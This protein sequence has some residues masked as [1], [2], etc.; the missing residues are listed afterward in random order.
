MIKLSKLCTVLSE[1]YPPQSAESWD[2]PGLLVGRG[3]SEIHRAI[4]A[5]ELTPNVLEEARK[6]HAELIITHHPF[7]FKPLNALTDSTPEGALLHALIRENIALYAAHTNFDAA[8]HAIAEKLARDLGISSYSAFLPHQSYAAY[9]IVVFAPRDAA[10]A[11]SRAMHDAGAGCVGHYRDVSF[12]CDGHGYFTGDETTHPSIG[13]PERPEIVEETKIEMVVSQRDLKRVV[14][15]MKAAHPYEEAAYDVFKIE[16]PVH[17]ISDMYGFGTIGKLPQIMTLRDFAQHLKAT[18]QLE[19][20]RIANI[21]PEKPIEKVAILNGSGAKYLKDCIR[22]GADAYITG[23]CGHHDF[24][25]AMRYNIA[26]IDA[27]HFDT[28]KYIPALMRNAIQEAL[29]SAFPTN[30][31]SLQVAASMENPI[32]YY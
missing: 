14:E 9:K 22:M 18:W 17:G 26:L 15:A 8:P 30:E 25:L 13:M 1:L 20:L 32:R 21:A 28:E 6:N 27:G 29:K 12:R 10:Q 19:H 4:L 2:N 16:A 3:A 24:D 23:D 5:L 7:I 11:V 31:F